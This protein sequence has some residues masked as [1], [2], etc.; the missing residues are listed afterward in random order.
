MYYFVENCMRLSSIP[1]D[2][3]DLIIVI[4]IHNWANPTTLNFLL[5][6][7]FVYYYYTYLSIL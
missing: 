2:R 7:L 4:V 6:S 3:M 1:V 5:V